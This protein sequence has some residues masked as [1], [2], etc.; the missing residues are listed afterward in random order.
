MQELIKHNFHKVFLRNCKILEYHINTKIKENNGRMDRKSR[1]SIQKEGL[2]NLQNANVLVVGLGG[3]GSFAAEFL[4]R[5][6]N[7]DNC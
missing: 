2:T 7:H 4:A 6:G 1:T 3:V 5:A